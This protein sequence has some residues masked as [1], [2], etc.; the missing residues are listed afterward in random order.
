MSVNKYLAKNAK[1]I[2]EEI[3]K[4]K[5]TKTVSGIALV[6]LVLCMLSAELS[7]AAL[8]S[9]QNWAD[10]MAAWSGNIQNY[11]G[12]E[13]GA[14]A[15]AYVLGAP[16]SDVDGNGYALDACDNDY[17]A[18]WKG[19]GDVSFTVYFETALL[20]IDG[21]DLAVKMYGGPNCQADVYGS[22]DGSSFEMIVRPVWRSTPQWTLVRSI[23]CITSGLTGLYR[24]RAPACSLMRLAVCPSRRPYFFWVPDGLRYLG[25]ASETYGRCGSR[26]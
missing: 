6:S 18:G 1:K 12:T 22:V 15:A 16:D 25:F 26:Q 2:L 11:N 9:G 24:A 17:V 13:T 4:M 8:V 10:T 19:I 20:N 3:E 7:S 14:I 5:S 21:D 23:T